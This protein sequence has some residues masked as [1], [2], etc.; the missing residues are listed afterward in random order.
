M[1]DK[2][3]QTNQDRGETAENLGTILLTPTEVINYLTLDEIGAALERADVEEPWHAY[4]VPVPN[5]AKWR[6]A[7][8]DE[9]RQ[10][11][12]EVFLEEHAH[13]FLFA[14]FAGRVRDELGNG[15]TYVSLGAAEDWTLL[16]PSSF[17]SYLSGEELKTAINRAAE[18]RPGWKCAVRVPD[19]NAWRDILMEQTGL[20]LD[21][22]ANL[23]MFIHSGTAAK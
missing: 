17:L 1:K 4:T 8:L 13:Y 11:A 20:R 15:Q 7:M 6:A 23:E 10:Q 3:N 16:A 2:N 22:D 12:A 18:D 5:T 9:D 14:V 21:E 19:T